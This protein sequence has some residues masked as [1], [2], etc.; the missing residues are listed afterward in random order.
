MILCNACISHFYPFLAEDGWTGFIKADFIPINGNDD[1]PICPIS[2]KPKNPHHWLVH[3]KYNTGASLSIKSEAGLVNKPPD[4]GHSHSQWPTSCTATHH[5]RMYTAAWI[6]TFSQLKLPLKGS[7]EKFIMARIVALCRT[8]YQFVSRLRCGA[9]THFFWP[10]HRYNFLDQ[11][12][13]W[14]SITAT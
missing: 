10:T 1:R 14:K 5:G 2:S 13:D 3:L 11:S 12:L 7:L 4:L 6:H 9:Q 8:R